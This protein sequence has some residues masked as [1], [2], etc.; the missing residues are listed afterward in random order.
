LPDAGSTAGLSIRLR[1]GDAAA[2]GGVLLTLVPHL[3]VILVGLALCASAIFVC[4]S[5][6]HSYVGAVSGDARSS[7]AGLYVAFT[8][9]WH[10]RG[11]APALAWQIG[12]WPACVTFI[13]AVQLITMRWRSS[14][15]AHA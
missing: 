7:A 4:Q 5:A 10:C 12:G 15:G 1:R 13:V 2:S 14:S 6:A 8:T 9:W 11:L 3:V